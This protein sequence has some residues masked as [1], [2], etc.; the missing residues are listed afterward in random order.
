MPEAFKNQKML[1]DIGKV[2]AS[3]SGRQ[4]F[5]ITAKGHVGKAP[6]NAQVGNEICVL[7]GGPESHFLL[8]KRDEIEEEEEVWEEKVWELIGDCFVHVY[9]PG[10][11]LADYNERAVRRFEIC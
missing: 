9:I 1:T 7:F 11:K 6:L 10:E 5:S 8:R 3:S 4:R 2:M